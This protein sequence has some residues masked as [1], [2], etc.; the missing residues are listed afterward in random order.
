MSTRSRA[1]AASILALT[2][3]GFVLR[4]ICARGD[5]W[6]D[7]IWSLQNLEYIGTI[8]GIFWGI[9]QNNNHI[10]NSLW[11]WF[12]G[13]DAS[14]AVV[15]LESIILGT[16]TIPAAAKLCGRSGEVAG[17]SG[18]ALVAFG[19][20]FVHYGSEARGYAGLILM[21]FVAADTLEDY[22]EGSTHRSRWIF[23]ACVALGALF[24]LTM[25]IAAFVLI[26]ATLARIQWRSRSLAHTLS[27]GADLA[28]PAILGAL[29]ALSF[30]IAGI[31]V[32]HKIQLGT[33]VPFSFER[34][35]QGL[36]TLCE[37]TLGLP[38]HWPLWLCAMIAILAIGAAFLVVA[39]E[40]RILP[41]SCLFLPPLIAILARLPNVHIARF[42]LVG[43]VGLVI[44]CADLFAKLRN[45]RQNGFAL[46][47]AFAF[48][49]GNALNVAPLIAIGRGDYRG[50]VARMETFAPAT[51]ASDLPAEVGRTIR[52]YD[53]HLGGRLAPLGDDWCRK[54]PD[55]FVFSGGPSGE[56][57]HRTFGPS[58]CPT[59][60]DLVSVT[61]P[62][63]LSGL[64]L[65]LYRRSKG[66]QGP[67]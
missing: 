6:L 26:A 54:P 49:T 19:A 47:L 67:N 22:L 37:A 2:L 65:A 4:L 51:Y 16:L 12:V 29:P 1:F 40:R 55:W 31:A 45:M 27:A 13:P 9:S 56:V 43:A 61:Q 41:F 34:L 32:T 57:P 25:L 35:A 23:G 10:L 20:I 42:H 15:R 18:A 36:A 66:Q 11:L 52:F 30:L 60:F 58:A 44:L 63:P 33:Q 5:L 50:L 53:R 21:I 8:G 24:H 14:P 64:R 17:L 48:A 38:Y 28:L 46:A 59:F 3:A 39:P 62:A 7:E